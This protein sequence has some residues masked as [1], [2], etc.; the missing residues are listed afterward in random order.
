M[1][2]F[3]EPVNVNQW[4]MFEEVRFVGHKEPFLATKAMKRGDIIL[5]H[6]GQQNKQYESGIYAIGEVI[7]EPC[8][9]QDRPND[10]CNNKLSVWVRIEKISYSTPFI[11]HQRCKDFIKQFR[12]VH[13]ISPENYKKIFDLLNQ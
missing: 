6:V 9:I 8:I 13:K 7:S 4:N 3:Y 5:L 11:S 10:Y 2:I 1:N 12:A